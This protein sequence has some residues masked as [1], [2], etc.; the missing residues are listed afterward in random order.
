M[1]GLSLAIADINA[2]A[3]CPRRNGLF[4]RSGII[5]NNGQA[6]PPRVLATHFRVNWP[7]PAL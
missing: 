7:A 2:P 6:P 5:A 3:H 4:A 1:T